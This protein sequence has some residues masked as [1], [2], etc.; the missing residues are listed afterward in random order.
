MRRS[1]VNQCS[2]VLFV[3]LLSA[4]MSVPTRTVGGQSP[5]VS[6]PR[7]IKSL[8]TRGLETIVELYV[9]YNS[10]VMDCGGP[11]LPAV[12]CSGVP[13][14]ATQNVP[15]GT[16]WEP[17]ASSI[18]SGGTSFSWLR[19]DANF[20]LIPISRTNGF[21]FYPRMRTPTDK[22]GNIEVLC[23]FS[24]DGLT[25]YRDEQGC[26]ESKA[27]PVESRPC[28]IVGVTTAAQ[29]FAMWDA[30][31]DKMSQVCGFNLRESARDQAD[32]FVQV[33]LAKH[34]IPDWAWV[35]W[36]ELRLATWAQGVGKDL[37]I[38]AFFYGDGNADGLASARADQQKYFD[39]YAQAIPI[40]R[41]ALPAAKG[42]RAQF[43]YSDDDQAVH[44][45]VARR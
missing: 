31:F 45:K 16:P 17:S 43:S 1:L 7:D 30:A 4:C 42:G 29:W 32:R 2:V 41:I 40:V 9:Y 13:I 23:G 28:D 36:N 11:Q 3:C 22:I 5:G 39:L 26:G 27:Y 44:E 34:M 21:I 19:Q 18:E 35:Q 12:L 38:I 25:S 6:A 10:T 15:D 8:H 37:P 14:R 20:S 24:M 33:I